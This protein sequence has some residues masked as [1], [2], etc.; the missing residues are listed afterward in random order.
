[1]A[2]GRERRPLDRQQAWT[3]VPAALSLLAG[4]PRILGKRFLIRTLRRRVP[5][6]AFAHLISAPPMKTTVA[7]RG[8]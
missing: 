3:Y 6:R 5:D 7:S 1:V 8:C 2:S 4:L